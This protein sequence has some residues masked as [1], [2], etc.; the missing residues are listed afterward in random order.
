MEDMKMSSDDAKMEP[1]N[2]NKKAKNGTMGEGHFGEGGDDM[3]LNGR[4]TI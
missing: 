2:K 4:M 1:L 3:R